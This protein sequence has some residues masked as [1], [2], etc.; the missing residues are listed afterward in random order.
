MEKRLLMGFK[1]KIVIR[2]VQR[3]IEEYQLCA[4]GKK[5]DSEDQRSCLLAPGDSRLKIKV[6]PRAAYIIEASLRRERTPSLVGQAH[7]TICCTAS[8]RAKT[9]RT[10]DM[11]RSIILLCSAICMVQTGRIRCHLYGRCCPLSN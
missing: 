8:L 6:P 10:G 5:G 4:V 2:A 11:V 9:P 7:A 3:R 1:E